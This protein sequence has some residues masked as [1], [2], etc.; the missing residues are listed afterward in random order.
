MKK[1]A[2]ILAIVMLFTLI[3]TGC[4]KIRGVEIDYGT[5]EIYEKVDLQDGITC[6]FYEFV[7]WYSGDK[8]YTLTYAGDDKCQEKLEN[9]KTRKYYKKYDECMIFYS[10]IEEYVW[11]PPEDYYNYDYYY[12]EDEENGFYEYKE[13]ELTWILGKDGN[14]DWELVNTKAKY[15]YD[16]PYTYR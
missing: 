1:T 3:A 9:W 16:G 2:L 7:S 15:N 13:N 4:G 5:S 12:F 10:T 11:N 8:L 14:G 6:I